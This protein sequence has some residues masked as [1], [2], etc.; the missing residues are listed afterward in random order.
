MET[1]IPAGNAIA[2][3]TLPIP[4]IDF[5]ITLRTAIENELSTF[6]EDM[7]ED[8]DNTGATEV[9]ILTY[10]YTKLEDIIGE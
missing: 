5:A 7:N 9:G 1:T 3:L 8:F 2:K 4:S 10:F 6:R